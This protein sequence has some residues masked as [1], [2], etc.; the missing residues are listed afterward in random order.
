[1]LASGP[2]PYGRGSEMAP[3]PWEPVRM[4][5]LKSCDQ[6]VVHANVL[7]DEYCD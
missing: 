5:L 7:S 4:P 2:L 6:D 3:V 1:M